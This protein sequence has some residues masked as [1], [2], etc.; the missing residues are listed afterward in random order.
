MSN[1]SAYSRCLIEPSSHHS[2][3]V[4]GDSHARRVGLRQYKS[5]V[6]VN[7]IGGATSSDI[8]RLLSEI[9]WSVNRSIKY[10]FILLGAND[11]MKNRQANHVFLFS[12]ILG[13][14]RNVFPESKICIF[15]VF[16]TTVISEL[17]ANKY[18]LGISDYL[19]DGSYVFGVNIRPTAFVNSL[20]YDGVHFK[21]S[22]YDY[23]LDAIHNMSRNNNGS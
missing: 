5:F 10:V 12:D 9:D 22:V 8:R 3:Y 15:P 13:M 1:L 19:I 11:I 6:H 21:D 14:L 23:I 16:V 17:S 4:L 7:G 18:N 20:L 2:V